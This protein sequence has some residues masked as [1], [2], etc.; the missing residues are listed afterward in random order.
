[1][2]FHGRNEAGTAA[3]E[4]VRRDLVPALRRTTEDNRNL[5]VT[6]LRLRED[7]VNDGADLAVYFTDLAYY[8]SNV[9]LEITESVLKLGPDEARYVCRESRDGSEW[10]LLVPISEAGHSQQPDKARKH[11]KHRRHLQREGASS[12]GVRVWVALAI[13]VLFLLVTVW[14][15]EALGYLS[16]GLAGLLK[17]NN[18]TVNPRPRRRQQL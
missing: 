7:V 12:W 11:K 14:Y 10:F 9:F 18:V 13:C 6:E 4:T 8:D 15:F 1:M 5:N 2:A 3:Y 16:G 17:T